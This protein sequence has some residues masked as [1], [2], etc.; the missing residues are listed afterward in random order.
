MTAHD[1]TRERSALRV[2][3]VIGEFDGVPYFRWRCDAC[4]S[5]RFGTY[6]FVVADA[7]AHAH[8]CPALRLAQLKTELEKLAENY[9]LLAERADPTPV[10]D[11]E[12]TS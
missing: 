12:V 4:R 8:I 7:H 2:R 1:G 5:E 10:P 11:P 6:G 9:R 3:M